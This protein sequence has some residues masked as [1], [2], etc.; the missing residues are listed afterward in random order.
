[1]VVLVLGADAP[2]NA[3]LLDFLVDVADLLILRDGSGA[4]SSICVRPAPDAPCDLALAGPP[5]LPDLR[6]RVD[7]A[8]ATVCSVCLISSNSCCMRSFSKRCCSTC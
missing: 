8:D 6:W 4:M 1:M 5:L 2:S 7:G 3:F